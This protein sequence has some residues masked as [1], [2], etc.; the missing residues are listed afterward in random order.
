MAITI[1]MPRLGMKMTEGTVVAW[2]VAPG[3][4]VEVGQVVLVI[5][6]DKS[7]VEIEA[8]EKGF[9]R[10]LYVEA[11]ETVACGTLLAAL[12]ETADEPF[13]PARFRSEPK[14][15]PSATAPL[16]SR[17][18]TPALS[19]SRR[20]EAAPVTPAARRL[21]RELSV[22]LARVLGTGP[23]GRVTR[24]D[25]EAL[26][27]ARD[28]RVAVA[29]GIHLEIERSGDGVPVLLLP[30]FGADLS[31]F[32]LQHAVLARSYE[33]TSLNPR[34]VGLSDAPDAELWSVD[35][36]AGDAAALIEAPAHV[37]GASLGAAVALELALAEPGKLRSLTLLTPFTQAGPTLL[38]VI[39]AWCRIGGGAAPETLA[40]FLLPWLFSDTLLEDPL[41]RERAVRGLA[42]ASPRVPLT[43]L[44]RWAG[45]L[46]AWSGRHHGR[47]IDLRVPTR[48]VAAGGDRLTPGGEA[49]AAMIPD[50]SLVVVSGAGHAVALEAA[51][52]VNTALL[53]HFAITT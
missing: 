45:G 16:A 32:A 35:D 7:E 43:S 15:A 23:G 21:A 53:E 44:E 41:R 30:G 50:A 47:R 6:S 19:A 3:A 31:S 51:D 14:A 33:V 4:G 17:D 46:R 11:G 10:H 27:S 48:I 12:T 26:A 52:A 40:R 36:A 39:D 25:V 5:E 34:G 1:A 22:D 24:E 8:R 42:A 28:A 9:V 38:A 29:P 18:L 2:Q 37:V 20:G 49:L 13:D